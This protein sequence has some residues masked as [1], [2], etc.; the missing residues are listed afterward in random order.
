MGNAYR[1][2]EHLQKALQLLADRHDLI[3]SIRGRGLFFGLE[4]LKGD[5]VPA[6]AETRRLVNLMRD[7]GVLISKIGPH[8]NIL[9]MRP[10]LPF[11]R[12]N[13]DLL[14]STLDDSMA[15]L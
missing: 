5:N 13:A 4:L 10:P 8:D 1:V 11:S 7:R 15:H 12:D 2:G 14:L 3:G 6:T 9:K